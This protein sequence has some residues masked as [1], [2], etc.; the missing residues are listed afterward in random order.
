MR[1]SE[2]SSLP[3]Q[4]RALFPQIPP[5]LLIV[6]DDPSDR[7]PVITAVAAVPQIA[8]SVPPFSLSPQRHCT[9]RQLPSASPP[10]MSKK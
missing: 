2:D 8:A 9:T 7:L 4:N 10:M 5:P 6:R 3:G 1:V